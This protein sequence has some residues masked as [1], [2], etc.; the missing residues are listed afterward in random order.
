MS[1]KKVEI[2]EAYIQLLDES[3]AKR[4]TVNDIVA[5]CGVSRN[6]FYYYYSDISSLIKEIEAYWIK[7]IRMPD[8]VK[9]IFDCMKPLQEYSL[10]HRNGILRAYRTSGQQHFTGVLNRLWEA[11]LRRFVES[12]EDCAFTE[13]EHDFLTRFFKCLFVGMTL[14]W[15][16]ADMSYDLT[17][18][19]RRACHLMQS[20]EMRRKFMLNC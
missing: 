1:N 3:P 20:D 17:A 10:E 19:G 9:S 7:L 13:E 6:T 5:R 11:I 16:D 2:M 8:E 4:I 14:D 12:R 18:T 15:L